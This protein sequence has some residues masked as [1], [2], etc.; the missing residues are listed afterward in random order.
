MSDTERVQVVLPKKLAGQ[1]REQVPS[2]KRSAWIAAAIQDRLLAE[3]RLD[4][5]DRVFGSWKD[6]EFPG[7]DTPDDIAAWR[8]AVWSGNASNGGLATKRG[9]SGK[10]AGRRSA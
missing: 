3:R 10:K 8:E 5:I 6:E 2:R 9:P 1:L 7:L 4:V